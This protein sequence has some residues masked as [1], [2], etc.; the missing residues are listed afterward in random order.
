MVVAVLG[1]KFDVA[2]VYF[3][4]TKRHKMY[5]NLFENYVDT[6]KKAFT[7]FLIDPSELVSP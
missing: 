5:E 1:L 2:G 7:Y 3:W 4:N 6:T